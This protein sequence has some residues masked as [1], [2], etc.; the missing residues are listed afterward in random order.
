[1]Q[2]KMPSCSRSKAEILPHFVPQVLSWL[3]SEDALLLAVVSLDEG[4]GETYLVA[5]LTAAEAESSSRC[6]LSTKIFL[7][8]AEGTVESSCDEC[9]WR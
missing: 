4:G 1:M 5:S 3:S 7:N 6:A 8:W 2:D 9:L